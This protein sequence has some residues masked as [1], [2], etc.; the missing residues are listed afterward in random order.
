MRPSPSRF[1]AAFFAWLVLEAGC[2]AAFNFLVDPLQLY[3]IP[4]LYHPVFWGGMQ[5]FQIP[6]IAK[7]YVQGITVVGTSITENFL[8][9]EFERLWGRPAVRLSMAGAT[10]HE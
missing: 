10:A 8:S 9:S 2:L 3:R 1:L 5:R 6:G 7:H 4:T